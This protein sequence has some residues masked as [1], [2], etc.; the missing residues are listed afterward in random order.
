MTA[1]ATESPSEATQAPLDTTQVSEGVEN[2]PSPQGV[3][4]ESL[5]K[6]TAALRN[7]NDIE[8]AAHYAGQTLAVVYRWLEL[9]K[10]EAERVAAGMMSD[11]HKQEYLEFWEELR[12]ARAE[13]IVRN[14]AYVQTAA[15]NGSWQAAAWWLERTVPE[16]YSR[17]KAVKQQDQDS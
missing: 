2:I 9:G 13:A 3:R 8:T 15:K 14:V 6:M 17:T 12:R 7:G 1:D 16:T 11:P 5:Q 10:Y 4:E